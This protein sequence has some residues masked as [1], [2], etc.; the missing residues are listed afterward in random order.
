MK[1]HESAAVGLP[2]V[3]TE[4]LADQLGW[5]NGVEL[6]TATH[7][8]DFADACVRL[9]RDPALWSELRENGIEAVRRDCS[10]EVFQNTIRAVLD[11]LRPAHVA[12]RM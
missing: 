1:L 11:G 2:A 10:A 7:A 12:A 8:Q 5:Q 4:L 9:Y 6:L 3:A